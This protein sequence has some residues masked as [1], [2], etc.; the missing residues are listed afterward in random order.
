MGKEEQISQILEVMDGYVVELNKFYKMSDSDWV[1]LRLAYALFKV[2]SPYPDDAIKA[3]QFLF[4]KHGKDV[5]INCAEE[6]DK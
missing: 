3:L 2:S 5:V 6:L 4:A 1:I